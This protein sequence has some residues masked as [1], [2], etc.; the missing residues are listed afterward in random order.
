MRL[1]AQSQYRFST[2][3]YQNN[4]PWRPDLKIIVALAIDVQRFSDYFE[5]APVLG[6][7]GRTYPV[8]V[9]YKPLEETK[10]QDTDQQLYQSIIDVLFDIDIENNRKSAPGDVLVFL[11]G[12]RE[13]KELSNEIKKSRIK[14]FD[15]LPLYSRLS[16][17]E[18]NRVFD[19]R[20]KPRIILATNVAETSLTVPRIHYVIDPGL[21][22]ISR[23]SYK[24]KIQQ[25]PVE[26]VSQASAEQRKGRCGN[27]S[28]SLY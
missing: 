20:G 21:A 23:Y 27:C 11:P 3:V 17:A 16:V 15:I 6:V 14:S 13:I 18:Q 1:I 24:S 12:E 9:A 26:K 4:S 28:W 22:R 8:E 10:S 7:A 25:L 2:W 5:D 19:A